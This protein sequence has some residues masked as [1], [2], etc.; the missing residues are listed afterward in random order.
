MP[1][2]PSALTYVIGLA[3]I[4]TLGFIV[5]TFFAGLRE[6]I[7]K[8]VVDSSL[9]AILGEIQGG[10][11]ELKDDMKL[12]KTAQLTMA[13]GDVL[14]QTE[15]NALRLRLETHIDDYNRW[16]EVIIDFRVKVQDFMDWASNFL[17]THMHVGA[18]AEEPP[19]NPPVVST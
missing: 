16:R 1:V 7:V 18:V 12:V 4:A 15:M 17:K 5:R 2:E 9:K 19:T 13:Q 14:K 6:Y 10:L 8:A 11:K 3:A